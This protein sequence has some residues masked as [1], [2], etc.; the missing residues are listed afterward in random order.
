MAEDKVKRL[1]EPRYGKVSEL[2]SSQGMTAAE[3]QDEI[4]HLQEEMG[5]LRED[6]KMSDDPEDKAYTRDEIAMKKDEVKEH[7]AEIKKLAK[8]PA[9]KGKALK[10]TPAE[11]RVLNEAKTEL[12]KARADLKK[13]EERTTIE[14]KDHVTHKRHR[15]SRRAAQLAL[16]CAKWEKVGAA[17]QDRREPRRQERPG[18]SGSTRRW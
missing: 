6:I 9:A 3:H 11:E 7:E 4:D 5:S 16:R 13:I 8:R 2:V 1:S 12:R 10:R 17:D 18:A 14:G 15:C